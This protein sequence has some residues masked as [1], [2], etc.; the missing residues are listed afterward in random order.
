MCRGRLK[1]EIRR[2][3][4]V[5]EMDLAGK[6]KEISRDSTGILKRVARERIGILRDQHGH[7]C[8]ATRDGQDF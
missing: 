6:V 8:G 1:R 7:L 5:R 4:I 2:L 3:Q